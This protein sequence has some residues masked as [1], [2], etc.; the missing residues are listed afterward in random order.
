MSAESGLTFQ[1][2][3]LL[4]FFSSWPLAQSSAKKVQDQFLDHIIFSSVLC[5]EELLWG[6]KGR[7]ENTDTAPLCTWYAWT[8]RDTHHASLLQFPLFPT[9]ERQN[10][11]CH[12]RHDSPTLPQAEL[13]KAKPH[14]C[15]HLISFP[16]G[17][18]PDLHKYF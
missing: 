1:Y 10:T 7:T 13:L 2:V 12:L 4:Q 18:L 17:L 11:L 9:H 5:L 16:P 15:L 3:P 6:V 14:R 8:M